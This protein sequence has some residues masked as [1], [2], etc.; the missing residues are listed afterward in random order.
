MYEGGSHIS[1]L[2]KVNAKKKSE[3]L[4][5]CWSKDGLEMISFQFISRIIP[6]EQTNNEKEMR[7]KEKEVKHHHNKW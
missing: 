5:V 2:V 1:S 4:V 6:K 7:L 3:R